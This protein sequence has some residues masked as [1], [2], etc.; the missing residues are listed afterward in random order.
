MSFSIYSIYSIPEIKAF[1]SA[2]IIY[3][4][5]PHIKWKQKKKRQLSK[6]FLKRGRVSFFSYITNKLAHNACIWEIHVTSTV[7]SNYPLA[8]KALWYEEVVN[9]LRCTVKP[10]GRHEFKV[11]DQKLTCRQLYSN[12]F[13]AS[14]CPRHVGRWQRLGKEGLNKGST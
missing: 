1:I 12:I 13:F 7:V 8:I 10:S 11:S 9:H 6:P 5:I 4:T 3:W 2:A 14:I